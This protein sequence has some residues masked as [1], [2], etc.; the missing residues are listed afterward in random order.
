LNAS[1][2]A[3]NTTIPVKFTVVESAG[4]SSE[5]LI[6]FTYEQCYNYFNYKGALKIPAFSQYARK[7]GTFSEKT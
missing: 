7:L 6:G 2:D 1:R 4:V 3:E 5:N